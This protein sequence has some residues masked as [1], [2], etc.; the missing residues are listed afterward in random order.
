MRLAVQTTEYPGY[1]AVFYL[2]NLSI[3]Y[4][5]VTTFLFYIVTTF[6]VGKLF[7]TCSIKI[8]HYDLQLTT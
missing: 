7:F 6:V 5:I 8:T 2:K 3:E 1:A 4:N